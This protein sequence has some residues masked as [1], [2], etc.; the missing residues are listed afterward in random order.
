[1]GTVLMETVLSKAYEKID[2]TLLNR[3][4]RPIPG[5]NLADY[6]TAKHNIVLT[7]NDMAHTNALGLI[8]GL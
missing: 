2:L 3:L 5:H 8:R 6:I 1:M 7:Y 4:L